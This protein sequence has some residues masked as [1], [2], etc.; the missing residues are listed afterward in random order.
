MDRYIS[1]VFSFIPFSYLLIFFLHS[2][3]AQDFNQPSVPID[4]TASNTTQMYGDIPVQPHVSPRM[5]FHQFNSEKTSIETLNKRSLFNLP[6]NP[7]NTNISLTWQNPQPQGNS[8]LSI[9]FV[10]NNLGWAV[11]ANGTI[12]TTPDKGNTWK[13][14]DSKTSA[15]LS[16]VYFASATYGWTVGESG[17]ILH[18]IDGGASWNAQ[19]SYTSRH[20]ASV[21]FQDTRTGFAV[22]D[23]GTILRTDDGGNNWFSKQTTTSAGLSGIFFLNDNLGWVCGENGTILRT[24]DGGTSWQKQDNL[25]NHWLSS[26]HFTTADSGWTVGELGTLLQTSNGGVTWKNRSLSV[27]TAHWLNRITFFGSKSGWIAGWYGLI[28]NTTDGGITWTKQE[29]NTR[30]DFEDIYCIDEYN[31]LI[32]GAWGSIFRTTDGGYKWKSLNS[33]WST[34]HLYGVSFSDANSGWAVGSN[35]TIL[36]TL[37]GGGTWG[38]QTGGTRYLLRN[39][40]FFDRSTG[41]AVGDS[42]IIVKTANGGSS[43]S[44]QT[45]GT[46]SWL[47]GVH[48][49]S[50][51]NGW[52]AGAAGTILHT[53]DGGA[54]WVSYKHNYTEWLSGVYFINEINGWTVG[55][56]GT[57]L[58][59]DNGGGKWIVDSLK[60]TYNWLLNVHFVDP[61]NGWISGGAG[62]ILH[63]SDGGKTWKKQTSGTENW[64]YGIYFVDENHGWAAGWS[65]TILQTIDGGKTWTFRNSNTSNGLYGIYAADIATGWAVGEGGAILKF[66]DPEEGITD[67]KQLEYFQTARLNTGSYSTIVVSETTQVIDPYDS[68]FSLHELDEIGIFTPDSISIC[69]GAEKW[70]KHDLKLTVWGNDAQTPEFDGFNEGSPFSFRIWVKER[71]IEYKAAPT[72]TGGSENFANNGISILGS[73]TLKEE[74]LR[75]I[76]RRTLQSDRTAGVA[77]T[78]NTSAI[79]KFTSGE[80]IARRATF[81]AYGDSLPQKLSSL[82]QLAHPVHY[83]YFS[84]DTTLPFTATLT[85]DYGRTDSLGLVRGI[86]PNDIVLAYFDSTVMRWKTPITTMDK[87][88]HKVSVEVPH[89]SLWALTGKNDSILVNITDEKG[90]KVPTNY[91][92]ANSFPNPF[93]PVTFI[94]YRIPKSTPVILKVY[95]VIGQEIVTLVDKTQP[96]GEYEIQW[97]GQNRF[98]NLVVSGVYFYRLQAGNFV[99]TKKMMV[100]R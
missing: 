89:L 73:L 84:L 54:T 87:P 72:F 12:L 93:N 18:T 100:V 37:D 33:R 99:Q 98:N 28:L 20:L 75:T 41:W 31:G 78:G 35:G 9:Y 94:R 29:S 22:G 1:F 61:M 47:S 90:E 79:L 3:K 69:A 86:S 49:T 68:L 46:K 50:V 85:I 19:N 62:T 38:L 48:F 77:F 71:G 23:S 43:W 14:Q 52:I 67:R 10:S 36:H 58:H 70:G 40:F 21:F 63:T 2:G 91:F 5:R 65:G 55:R 4:S 74:N 16:G 45:S 57:I 27:K 56:D 15:W 76:I 59:T 34:A 11:G 51:S 97:N 30:D 44:F 17:A 80:I 66:H 13:V 82:P 96:A 60:I 64:L 7:D 25:T 53:T 42:G 24:A 32:V 6:K 81:I 83:Y 26:I 88:S 8:L 39:V 95:N 92:L